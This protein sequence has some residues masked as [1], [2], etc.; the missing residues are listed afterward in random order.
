MTAAER[1]VKRILGGG[2]KE[3]LPKGNSS[4]SVVEG[5]EKTAKDELYEALVEDALPKGKTLAEHDKERHPDG[6]N[7][8]TDS[9]KFR[10]EMKKEKDADRA[11]EISPESAPKAEGGEEGGQKKPLVSAEEDKAYMEAVERGDMETAAKM[12]R[13]VAGRAFPNTKVVDGDGMPQ[14]QYHY[15]RLGIDHYLNYDDDND[16]FIP[17]G[18]THFGTRQAAADREVATSGAFDADEENSYGTTSYFLNIEN[19][20]ETQDG[21]GKAN[22][23]T[24]GAN[25]VHDGHD[26]NRYEN[27]IEG[28]GS[29]S[30]VAYKPSQIKSAD[31][32]TWDDEGNV[33]PLSRRFDDGDDI[34]GDVSSGTKSGEFGEDFFSSVYPDRT[35][36]Y[37]S[38]FGT[39]ESEEKAQAEDAYNANFTKG[40]KYKTPFADGRFSKEILEKAREEQEPNYNHSS[41]KILKDEY[42]TSRVGLVTPMSEGEYPEE[43]KFLENFDSFMP[44]LKELDKFVKDAAP[45]RAKIQTGRDTLEEKESQEIDG[46]GLRDIVDSFNNDSAEL[47]LLGLGLLGMDKEIPNATI[48]MKWEHDAGVGFNED[49]CDK[50]E[51]IAKRLPCANGIGKCLMYLS[52]HREA[53]ASSKGQA[54]MVRALGDFREWI[55]ELGHVL[56]MNKEVQKKCLAF[57]EYR[58]KSDKN[59]EN[60][61]SGDSTIEKGPY[62]GK[63]RNEIPPTINNYFMYGLEIAKA[64]RFWSKYC[65]KSYLKALYKG[66]GTKKFVP[67]NADAVQKIGEDNVDTYSWTYSTEIMA[68]GLERLLYEPDRFIDQDSEY[69]AFV[70]GV[71]KGV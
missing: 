20:K 12:V 46:G 48:N 43:L 52:N 56:C 55:H 63:K 39:D 60:I 50:F 67:Y 44:S 8:E 27:V 14:I 22:D 47:A 70:I 62:A 71:L 34:R 57:L 21:W 25:V 18:P 68:M 51:S 54:M 69:A 31:P 66:K 5:K 30:W 3:G 16:P 38:E 9:C 15:G 33:I 7:P 59:Y 6:F 28:K 64:D 35:Q 11:D 19:P 53:R 4:E 24:I 40:G 42:D 61:T 37:S 58:T 2:N 26:G 49:V 65:G 17:K 45:V 13:E 36:S 29:V 41:K 32:V 10:E 1:F 23:K